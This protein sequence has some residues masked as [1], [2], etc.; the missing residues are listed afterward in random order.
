MVRKL[1]D[2]LGMAMWGKGILKKNYKVG[3]LPGKP[4]VWV[5]RKVPNYI[6]DCTTYRADSDDIHPLESWKLS[7]YRVSLCFD[8]GDNASHFSVL[9][10]KIDLSEDK[11][12]AALVEYFKRGPDTAEYSGYD[13]YPIKLL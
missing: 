2:E 10:E 6:S 3:R 12:K 4:M 5:V 1:L 9:C 13:G 7:E 8:D 11:L